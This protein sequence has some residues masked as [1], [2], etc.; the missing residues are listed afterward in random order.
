MPLPADVLTGATVTVEDDRQDYGEDRFITIGFLDDA[1]VVLVWTSRD[2]ACR[3]ISMR[4]ANERDRRLYGPR[5]RPRHR[6]RPRR[7]LARGQPITGCGGRRAMRLREF[8]GNAVGRRMLGRV[9]RSR[10]NVMELERMPTFTADQP[11]CLPRL[12]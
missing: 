3:I 9:F 12:V 5:F 2:D 6:A 4:K 11:A 10:G 8:E 1:L 7:R